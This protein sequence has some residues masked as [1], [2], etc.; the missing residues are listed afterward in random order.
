M[1][2]TWALLLVTPGAALRISRPAL[3]RNAAASTAAAATAPCTV[4]PAVAGEPARA[5]SSD[6][7]FYQSDDKSFDFIAPRGWTI[8]EAGF[9]RA[10]G[11]DPRRF[12]PDHLFRVNARNVKSS[13]VV[14]VDLG[15]GMDLSSLGKPAAA[16]ERLLP[17]LPGPRPAAVS[18]VEKVSGVV[19]GSSYLVVRAED[20]RLLKA[21]VTQKKLYVMAGDQGAEGVLDSFQVWP[22]NIFCQGASNK[23]GPIVPGTCY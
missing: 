17:F 9:N 10:T 6:D 7:T 11:D 2:L 18:S 23:G 3:L 5:L 14:T 12:F 21:A 19:K 8:A 15:Y 1:S 16:A 22:T 13:V 4:A 20:G